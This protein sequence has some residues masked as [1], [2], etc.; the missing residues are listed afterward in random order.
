M[1]R[2]D[3]NLTKEEDVKQWNRIKQQEI[4]RRDDPNLKDTE[5]LRDMMDHYEG[6]N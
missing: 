3:I 1:D 4:N 5:L 6:D 2:K